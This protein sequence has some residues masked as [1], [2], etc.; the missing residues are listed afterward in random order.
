MRKIH[1]LSYHVVSTGV[2]ESVVHER[3]NYNRLDS[4]SGIASCRKQKFNRK[5]LNTLLHWDAW[6]KQYHSTYRQKKLYSP[7][8]K[9]RQ[10]AKNASLE[11]ST[12]LNFIPMPLWLYF[13]RKIVDFKKLLSFLRYWQ[14]VLQGKECAVQLSLRALEFNSELSLLKYPCCYKRICC[15]Y[16]F[17]SST[18]VLHALSIFNW[19]AVFYQLGLF[20]FCLQT[21]RSLGVAMFLVVLGKT[22]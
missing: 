9:W 13:T 15:R 16:V 21:V 5:V 17:L 19:S 3:P 1:F 10:T 22:K 4:C 12:G 14:W 11:Q 20:L 6:T 18:L 8:T 2:A 7:E